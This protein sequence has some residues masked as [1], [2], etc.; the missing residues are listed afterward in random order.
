MVEAE[1]LRQHEGLA[2]GDHGGAQ[3][4]VVADL[5]RLPRP[6][7]AAMDDALA[8]GLQHRLGRCEGL[9]RAAAHEGQRA[10]ARSARAPRNGGVERQQSPRARQSV[11]G[12]RAFHVDGG[13]IDQQRARLR[14]AGDLLP[15]CAHMLAGGQHGDDDLRLAH[16]IKGAVRPFQT[17]RQRRLARARRKIESPHA[18]SRAHEIERHGQAHI[19]EPDE[20]DSGH[21]TLRFFMINAPRV[22]APRSGA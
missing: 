10:R 11:R 20:C 21:S 16:A 22:R 18:A 19:A 8:H 9:R 3:N 17:A 1:L 15:H 4:H 13:G 2:G 7:A 6:R 14:G 12:A 5:G